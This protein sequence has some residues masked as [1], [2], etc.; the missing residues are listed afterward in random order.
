MIVLANL[1]LLLVAEGATRLMMFAATGDGFAFRYGF[2]PD[3]RVQVFQLSSLSFA[4]HREGAPSGQKAPPSTKPAD[5][6]SREQLTVWA[7]GG[8]TVH[9]HHCSTSASGWPEEISRLSP[10][11]RVVNFGRQ[12]T[13]TDFAYRQLASALRHGRPD[14]V[15]WGER[16]NEWD[17]VAFGLDR[18]LERLRGVFP[19]RVN[20]PS[21]TALVFA[22]RLHL[23]LYQR[24]LAFFLASEIVQRTM[25][26]LGYRA[27]RLE[28][29][30]EKTPREIDL[31]VRNYRHNTLDALALAE[32]NGFSLVI[33]LPPLKEEILSSDSPDS[34]DPFYAR[35]QEVQLELVRQHQPRLR[36]IDSRPL[37]RATAD[38][39]TH[40]CDGMHQLKEGH[41][42]TA[43]A[44]VEVLDRWFPVT[45]KP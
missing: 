4:F 38:A 26:V 41:A 19:E 3:V 27:P 42:I 21:G 5:A 39:A 10:R 8:S 17:V 23:T 37:H 18:N 25:W 22:H 28:V 45:V 16:P 11:Y 20:N 40:F 33:V 12:G 35:L 43:R 6:A 13:N 2:D 9:G 1:L 36:L 7:F 14:V 44:V 30:T 32:Q 15:L 31:A 34:P 29:A 24:S